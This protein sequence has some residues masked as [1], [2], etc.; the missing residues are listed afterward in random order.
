MAGPWAF[1][2]LCEDEPRQYDQALGNLRHG[3]S[4]GLGQGQSIADVA[5][6]HL[7]LLLT[8]F[9]EYE[10]SMKVLAVF[11]QRNLNHPSYIEAMGIAALR[12]PLLPV[13]APPTDRLLIMD[14]GRVMFDA[15]AL[16]TTEA[17]AEFK[18]LVE[19]YPDT[20]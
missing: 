13:E 12:K 17:G 11:A 15:A 5:N 20:P 9:E 18:V 10:A 1:L 7:A 8:R 6:F 16:R 3:I 4:L 19:K 14:V 2:G